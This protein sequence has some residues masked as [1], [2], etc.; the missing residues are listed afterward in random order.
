MAR[1]NPVTYE[2]PYKNKL[3]LTNPAPFPVTS[4]TT[5]FA[6]ISKFPC[7]RFT[8]RPAGVELKP[9]KAIIKAPYFTH[10][11][12][13]NCYQ[14]DNDQQ[15]RIQRAAAVRLATNTTQIAKADYN[16]LESLALRAELLPRP[17]VPHLVYLLVTTREPLS[18][19]C[20]LLCWLLA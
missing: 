14:E 10:T 2:L 9:G 1:P 19:F 17:I 7:C 5:P 13:R 15:E 6:H 3:S 20:L 16:K 4:L 18:G 8:H 12:L 11:T